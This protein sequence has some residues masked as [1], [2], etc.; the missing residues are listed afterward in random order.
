MHI[1]FHGAAG[2][3]TGSC[4]LISVGGRRILLDCGMIQGRR[5]DEARNAMPFPFDS[6][7]IDAVVLSHAHI[8]HS[9]RIPLLIK[10]GFTGPVYTQKAS[11][12]LCRIMLA[13]AAHLNERDAELEN[14]KRERKSLPPIEPLYTISDARSAMRQFRGLDYGVKK[15]ILPGITLRLV[16]AGHI[17]GSA[18]VELWLE[19]NGLRRKLVFSGDLGARDRPILHDPEYVRDADLVLMEST[20]GD[21][22]HRSREE[23][24]K[25]VLEIVREAEHARGNILIPAFA[26]G[27]TQLI[28]Y[29]FARNYREW[30]L[31]R[32]QVFLDSPMAIQAT[33]VYARHTELYDAE[34]AELW[35]KNSQQPML[36]NLHLCRTANQSMQLNKIRSGAVIIAGSGMCTG[37][38]IRHH[39]KHNVWRRDCHVVIV[40][41]QAEGTL[42][43]KLVD[44]AK[45]ISLWGETISV[46]AHVHT[47]GGLSAHA[48]QAG[49]VDWYGHFDSRPPLALVHGDPDS[50]E[51]L[52]EVIRRQTGATVIA[53]RRGARID[54]RRPG[55]A[56]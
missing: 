56:S 11:R 17:L 1:E 24:R 21:R 15:K 43:R 49:L 30:D 41:Y 22:L 45:R 51:V 6:A 42:G 12:D 44:G 37:G 2:E 19:E 16:D 3:V 26:V 40:G 47:V 9:G 46:C 38:R 7:A 13:D 48:D 4:H 8:D 54:L 14:R 18:I 5:S 23:T 33:E 20:Y 35:D 36:P 34:A 27:R 31:G 39:L 53:A 52:A 10:S 50:I 25:Q 29:E 28:L 55:K 32:W